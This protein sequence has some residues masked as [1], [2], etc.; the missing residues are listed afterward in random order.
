MATTASKEV[1]VYSVEKLGQV[2]HLQFEKGVVRNW[3]AFLKNLFFTRG[4]LI[5]RD[6]SLGTLLSQKIAS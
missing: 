1:H 3:A 5:C 2:G 4:H 6:H